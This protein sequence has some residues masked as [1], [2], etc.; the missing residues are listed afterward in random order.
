VATT[1]EAGEVRRGAILLSGERILRL[2]PTHDEEE[3]RAH[4]RSS[5]LSISSA[6]ELPG[7]MEDAV[8]TDSV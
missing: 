8:V 6:M 7:S 5:L 4:L 1:R 2:W 3:R